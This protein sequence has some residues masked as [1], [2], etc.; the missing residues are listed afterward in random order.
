M[1]KDILTLAAS[2][3]VCLLAGVI[4][5]IYTYPSIPTWYAG[6]IKPALNPPNWVFGPV[7]TTLYVFMGIALFLVIRKWNFDKAS[8]TALSVFALQLAFNSLWSIVFFGW[9]QLFGGLL[10]IAVLWCLIAASIYLM[11]KLN[12]WAGALLVPYLLWVSFASYLTWAVWVL[13][14]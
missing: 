1:I 11:G 4:G 8:I 14:R 5:S 7:W 10:V 6:L 3:A 2:I 9:R 12:K 13:N